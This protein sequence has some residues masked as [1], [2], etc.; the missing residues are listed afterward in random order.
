MPLFTTELNGLANSIGASDWTIRLHTAAPTNGSPTNGRTTVGGGGYENGITLDDTDITNASN[1]DI[2]NNVAIA[3]GTADENVGT[4]THCS[5]YRGN[6]PVGFVTVP[7][8]AI[9]SGDTFTINANTLRI[10]GSTS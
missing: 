5:V 1:G 8:T 3:F 10:N 4:V 9:N 7:S 6:T 2:Q